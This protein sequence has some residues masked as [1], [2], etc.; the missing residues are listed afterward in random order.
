MIEAGTVGKGAT[1]PDNFDERLL[2]MGRELGEA[3]DRLESR[4][5]GLATKLDT[6]LA[7]EKAAKVH[8][9]SADR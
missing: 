4:Y 5:P 2:A 1:Q 6:K 9:E 7:A 8:G 3:V